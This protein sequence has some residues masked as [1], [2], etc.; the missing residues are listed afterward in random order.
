VPALNRALPLT[1]LAL[2]FQPL[3]G[4]AIDLQPNDVVAPLPDKNYLMVS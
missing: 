4:W 3:I 2:L 1:L